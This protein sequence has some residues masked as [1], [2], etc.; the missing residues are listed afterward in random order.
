MRCLSCNARLTEFEATRRGANSMDFID[1][2]D[3]CFV[4][5]QDDINVIER[6]DL[7]EEG[8]DTKPNNGG[9]VDSGDDDGVDNRLRSCYN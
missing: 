8:F 5:I 6:E 9:V 3:R 7:E 1:L 2:C 4:H